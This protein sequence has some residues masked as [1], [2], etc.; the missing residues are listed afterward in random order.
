MRTLSIGNA[1]DLSSVFSQ[2]HQKM[3]QSDRL[4]LW[5][6][7]IKDLGCSSENSNI[8]RVNLE[9]SMAWSLVV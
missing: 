6:P 9:I 3:I 7:K 8:F 4:G 2:A 5:V 1:G